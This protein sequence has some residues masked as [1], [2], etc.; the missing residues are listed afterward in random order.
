MT[1]YQYKV[2]TVSTASFSAMASEM[3][4]MINDQAANGWEFVES[5][6]VPGGFGMVLVFRR[7]RQ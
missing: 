1:N 2:E 7:P 6:A 5:N 3:E 4:D